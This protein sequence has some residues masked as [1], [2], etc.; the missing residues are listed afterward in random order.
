MSPSKAEQDTVPAG[1][2]ADDGGIGAVVR[3]LGEA[4]A[5]YQ[6][7]SVQGHDAQLVEFFRHMAEAREA[8]IAR[9]MPENAMPPG[10]MADAMVS[11]GRVWLHLKT[12]FDDT[13]VVLLR[14]IQAAEMRALHA[15]DHVLEEGLDGVPIAPARQVRA[16]VAFALAGIGTALEGREGPHD[17]EA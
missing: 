15:L 17:P 6:Q 5:L 11:G 12:L 14:S 8:D 1:D 16:G 13:D 7:A 4:A 2:V 10:A 3:S 9:L